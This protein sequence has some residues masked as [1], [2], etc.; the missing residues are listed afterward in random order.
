MINL[1]M[2]GCFLFCLVTCKL[3]NFLVW[4]KC[5]SKLFSNTKWCISVGLPYNF[6]GHII[7]LMADVKLF[8][9]VYFIWV[10]VIAKVTVADLIA[11]FMADVIAIIVWLML[12]PLVILWYV[13]IT[14]AG[15]IANLYLGRSYCHIIVVDVVN[16]LCLKNI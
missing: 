6:I 5:L 16:T 8:F 4:G 2:Y 11:K 9:I 3:N 13:S 14:L 1:Y 7:I 15:V 12:L 10:D